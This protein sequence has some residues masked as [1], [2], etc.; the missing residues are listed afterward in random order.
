MEYAYQQ[1]PHYVLGVTIILFLHLVFIFI[2]TL[3]TKKPT[4]GSELIDAIGMSILLG[5][6]YQFSFKFIGYPKLIII[7][8]VFMV[9]EFILQGFNI[10]HGYKRIPKLLAMSVICTM[11]VTLTLFL[12]PGHF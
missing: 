8:L 7:A 2:H 11:Y 4:L 12:L 9:I 3:L 10:Y 1:H 5:W 6:V